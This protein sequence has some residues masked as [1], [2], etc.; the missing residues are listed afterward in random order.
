MKAIVAVK[1]ADVIDQPK[2]SRKKKRA[3]SFG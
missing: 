1:K 2:P 3:H